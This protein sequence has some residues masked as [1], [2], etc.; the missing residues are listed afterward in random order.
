MWKMF[1]GIQ[2]KGTYKVKNIVIFQQYV[3]LM[4]NFE[5]KKFYS[6]FGLNLILSIFVM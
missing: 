3:T 6:W 2:S 5:D 4:N 1:F